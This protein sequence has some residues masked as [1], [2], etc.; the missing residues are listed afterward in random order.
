MQKREKSPADAAR[1]DDFLG[2]DRMATPLGN[3]KQMQK[4][5]KS[6]ADAARQDD[7]LGC[8]NYYNIINFNT[9]YILIF[10]KYIILITTYIK[11]FFLYFIYFN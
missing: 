9:R 6:P 5:E 2:C 8:D 11:E 10:L 4:Q 3:S 1:Q 7:F